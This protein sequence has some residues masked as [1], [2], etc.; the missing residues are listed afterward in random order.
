MYPVLPHRPRPAGLGSARPPDMATSMG[1]NELDVTYGE[2]SYSFRPGEM[3]RIGRSPDNEIVVSD[4]TVSRQHAQI[5]CGPDGWEFV[6]T[7]RALSFVNGA[8]ATRVLVT[9]AT[10]LQLS[11]ERG[12][13]LS[14]TPTPAGPPAADPGATAASGG[15][16]GTVRSDYAGGGDPAGAA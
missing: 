2:R 16:H 1:M 7:G 13:V 3:V 6:S 15:Y 4:P 9:Q 11:S 8:Q 10:Q 5:S 14:L 12:P